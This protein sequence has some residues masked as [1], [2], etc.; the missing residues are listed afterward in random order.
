[1]NKIKKGDEVIV[2]T[3][4]DKGKVGSVLSIVD[5]GNRLLISGINV[6]KKHV[7]PNP[8]AN[9]AG[10]VVDKE[11]PIHRSNVQLY[12]ADTKKGS[13]IGIRQLKDGQRVRYYK[14]NDQLVE[15]KG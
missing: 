11:M 15:V 5:S 10:G 9:V 14:T 2:I 13:R 4:K 8:E 3:G 12:N 1:M 7:K 6:A